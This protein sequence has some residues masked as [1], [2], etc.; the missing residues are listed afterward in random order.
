MAFVHYATP[1]SSVIV[2]Y[3]HVLNEKTSLKIH[4][5]SSNF[6]MELFQPKMNLFCHQK[7]RITLKWFKVA[8]K[9]PKIENYSNIF[10]TFIQIWLIHRY[11]K[12]ECFPNTIP[13]GWYIGIEMVQ[14]SFW[15]SLKIT[16]TWNCK[17]LQKQVWK[18][19]WVKYF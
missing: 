16:T 18:F 3:F 11:Y 10:H 17:T 7:L 9:S 8:L 5:F 12:K 14:P 2:H 15:K 1:I 4:A 19:G 6:K 13:R